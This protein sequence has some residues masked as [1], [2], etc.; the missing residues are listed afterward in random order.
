MKL[1]T[2]LFW[3]TIGAMT[4]LL[5]VLLVGGA[6]LIE[7]ER[8]AVAREAVGRARSA[9]SA[10]DA[11]LRGSLTTLQ[12]LAS[13]KYLAAGNL[14]EFHEETKRVL[15]SQP[16][17][18]NVGLTTV[19][20]RAA[21]RADAPRGG[22]GPAVA[23]VVEPAQQRRTVY[24]GR[25]PH[26]AQGGAARA[27][28]DGTRDRQRRRHSR[29][30]A[31]ARFRHVLARGS[32]AVAVARRARYRPRAAR[33]VVEMHGG[34]IE[35]RSEGPGKGSEFVVR[36]P[37]VTAAGTPA[38]PAPAE[39]GRDTRVY[40]ILVVDD[41]EENAAS[42]AAVLRGMGHD[43]HTAGGGHEAV[44]A[45]ARYL[46]EVVLLDIQMPHVNGYEACRHIRGIP[47]GKSILIVAVT[48]RGQ[49]KDR[50]DSAQSGFDYHLVKP[51]DPAELNAL[52]QSL[53]HER[54]LRG[55]PANPAS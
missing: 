36:L 23:G 54:T 52:I 37:I 40:R 21:G 43:V 22:P 19:D 7:H 30:H 31:P 33:G 51:V 47:G 13:S 39:A 20:R 55:K 35:A 28:A 6:V 3:L 32:G 46:P 41:V 5:A 2:S 15:A 1:R 26:P 38:P 8:E 16:G 14:R 24:P 42:L 10:V 44:V 12:A 4:P 34:T 45:A 27:R 11:Q 17:W 53:G 29:A 48:G 50:Q 18:L 25:R 49:D 9:M